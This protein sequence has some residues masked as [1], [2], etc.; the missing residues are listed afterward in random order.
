MNLA[1]LNLAHVHLLLN[2][3]P[4]IGFGMALGLLLVGLIGRNEELKRASLVI[5]FLIAA[6][7]IPTY[8]SGNAAEELLRNRTEVN[9]NLVHAHE[10]AALLGFLF[11]EITGFVAWLGLWQFRLI[12][13]V[14]AWNV[15]AI[16]L[17]SVVAF[18]LIARAAN[19]GGDIRHP[20]I[21]GT[22][23]A[24]Q[25]AAADTANAGMAKSLGAAVITHTWVW[26]ACE[27]L[28]FV[29][30]CL[31]FT[32]VLVVDL[33]LLGMAKGISFASLY[34]LLPLGMLG[35]AL[36]LCTGMAFF[37]GASEQYTKNNMFYWKMI[38]VILGAINVLYFMLL[39]DAW[40]VGPGDDAPLT[41]KLVAA[42]AICVWVGVLF[43][44]HMLPFL[45]NAF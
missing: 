21:L 42:S 36:N 30:L 20:E 45:G 38:F 8:M 4:A 39:D 44:G 2:H 28:H 12:K 14:P 23:E 15:P 3:F 22:Q 13:R 34:Q 19:M 5:F 16:L 29:G 32:V 1:Q 37:I 7:T 10:D 43:F 40:T 31:L 25:D 24:A 11:I 35:F 33:R 18:G 17:L 41:A 6:I 9:Q 26:P 27:S